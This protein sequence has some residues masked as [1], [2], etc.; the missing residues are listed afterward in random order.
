VT[1]VEDP[2]VLRAKGIRIICLLTGIKNQEILL[3][4]LEG[5]PQPLS[6]Q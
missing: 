1:L 3:K 5:L 2:S 6:Y 4:G